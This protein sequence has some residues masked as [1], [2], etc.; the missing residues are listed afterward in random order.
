MLVEKILLVYFSTSEGAVYLPPIDEVFGP[1]FS[2]LKVKKFNIKIAKMKK[3]FPTFWL[4]GCEKY[5]FCFK[6][7]S[8]GYLLNF[9]LL[10]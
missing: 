2:S 1:Q 7:N 9:L 3:Y 10:G 4:L 6:T 5:I 8:Q